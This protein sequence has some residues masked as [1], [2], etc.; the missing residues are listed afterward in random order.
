MQTFYNIDFDQQ[1]DDHVERVVPSADTLSSHVTDQR[2]PLQRQ[3]TESN[4]S[5]VQP[6]L[7][8]QGERLQPQQQAETAGRHQD[9]VHE[10][11]A[12]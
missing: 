12:H 2:V 10:M 9:Q 3:I 8:E 1:E 5:A 4:A 11:A 6:V 7:S